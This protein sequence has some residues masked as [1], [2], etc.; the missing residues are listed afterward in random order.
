LGRGTSEKREKS[1]IGGGKARGVLPSPKGSMTAGFGN[2]GVACEGGGPRTV[3]DSHGRK[4]A[5]W[6]GKKKR[7]EKTAKR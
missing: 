3:G 2:G 6:E 5:F 1:E 4:K 7:M